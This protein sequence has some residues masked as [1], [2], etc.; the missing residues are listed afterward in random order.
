MD[1]QLLRHDLALE[2]ATARTL[3]GVAASCS[4]CGSVLM[5]ICFAAFQESRRCGRRVLLCLHLADLGAA[6]AWLLVFALPNASTTGTTEVTSSACYAQVSWTGWQAPLQGSQ[7]VVCGV[8]RATCCCSSRLPR[9]S[10]QPAS[11]SIC[12]R[13]S[14]AATRRQSCT[15]AATTS[16]PGGSHSWYTQSLPHSASSSLTCVWL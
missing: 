11:P 4:L 7:S 8:F 5:L 16:S 2:M 6:C 3:V 9:I 14:A 10:G 13:S 12:I 15:N 1:E